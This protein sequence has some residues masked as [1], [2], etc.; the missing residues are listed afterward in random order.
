M[1]RPAVILAAG[2]GRR[3][4]G[5]KALVEI[6]GETMLARVT[7]GCAASGFAPLIAVVPMGL[8]GIVRERHGEIDVVLVNPDP[9]SGPLASLHIAMASLPPDAAGLLLAKVDFAMVRPATY[10]ALSRAVASDP[11]R[12]W[13]PVQGSRHGH[14]VWFP[15]SLFEALRNAPL[16]EG[17][18]AVVYANE[19]LWADVPVEDPG[20]FRDIDT[21]EDLTWAELE[22]SR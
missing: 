17:A 7:R 4:G 6:A 1:I 2:E 16:S 19:H 10:E 3:L 20:V 5:P 21:P 11:T 9:A 8:A 22:A 18:R 14:P 15:A 13:R 12:L